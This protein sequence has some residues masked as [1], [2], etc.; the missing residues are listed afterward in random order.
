[1]FSTIAGKTEI[2]SLQREDYGIPIKRI[3]LLYGNYCLDA[4]QVPPLFLYL[5]FVI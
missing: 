5:G 2:I 3:I 1:M 4:V